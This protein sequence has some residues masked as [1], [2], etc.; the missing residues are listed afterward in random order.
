MYG[1][2][3]DGPKIVLFRY[4]SYWPSVCQCTRRE[5]RRASE[6]VTSTKRSSGGGCQLSDV[7]EACALAS[8]KVSMC[9][10]ETRIGVTYSENDTIGVT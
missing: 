3:S 7:T 6:N 5:R 4:D 9:T 2:A 1:P 10:T 8:L